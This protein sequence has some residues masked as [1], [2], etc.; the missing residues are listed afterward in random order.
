MENTVVTLKSLIL[1]HNYFKKGEF[2]I[3]LL[4]FKVHMKY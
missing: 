4:L 3:N 1:L 2:L